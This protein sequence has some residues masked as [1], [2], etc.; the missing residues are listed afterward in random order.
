MFFAIILPLIYWAFSKRIGLTLS[1][2]LFASFY[3]NVF[4]KDLFQISRPF[5]TH[6]DRIS[7][8]FTLDSYSFPSGHAQHSLSF[9]GLLAALLRSKWVFAAVGVIVLC[10][11]IARMYAGVHYPSDVLTG[12]LVAILILG[13]A[14]FIN[15]WIEKHPLK[16]VWLIALAVL[17]PAVLLPLYHLVSGAGADREGAYQAAGLIAFSLLGY[18]WEREKIRFAIP[19]EWRPRV[20]AFIIGAIGLLL[21]KEGFKLALP[22]SHWSDFLRYGLL[23][24]W[25]IGAAPWLFIKL[26]LYRCNVSSKTE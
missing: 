16:T 15:S 21:I 3:L 4:L 8:Q 24:L 2:V 20:I 19:G 12:W 14:H 9:W 17:L 5:V 26:R 11:G 25:T 23:G 7:P 10:V 1:L 6:S 22:E 13:A 18:A